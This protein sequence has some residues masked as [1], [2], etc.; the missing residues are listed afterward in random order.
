MG[1][2]RQLEA[3]SV[4]IPKAAYLLLMVWGHFQKNTNNLPLGIL[5]IFT[6]KLYRFLCSYLLIFPTKTLLSITISPAYVLQNTLLS[7]SMMLD[8]LPEEV[9]I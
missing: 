4:K 9:L 3:F 1:S 2:T 6:C 8:S 7:F 5:M